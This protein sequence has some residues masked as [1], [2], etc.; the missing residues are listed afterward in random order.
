MWKEKFKRNTFEVIRRRRKNKQN[1]IISWN[2]DQGMLIFGVYKKKSRS[3]TFKRLGYHMFNKRGKAESEKRRNFYNDREFKI[4]DKDRESDV[5]LGV[6]SYVSKLIDN[7]IRN[8]N[9]RKL[10][11]DLYLELSFFEKYMGK[12]KIKFIERKIETDQCIRCKNGV[13]NWEHILICEKNKSS[14]KEV[15]ERSVADFEERLLIE[16]KP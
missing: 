5:G 9:R 11:E 14:I 6:N 2:N 7:F 13:E 8:S 3:K 12:N 4:T 15:L 16:E 1:E 10:D